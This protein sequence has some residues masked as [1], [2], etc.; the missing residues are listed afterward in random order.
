MMRR[1]KVKATPSDFPQ[2]INLK[3]LPKSICYKA[4]LLREKMTLKAIIA[5]LLTLL[6]TQYAVS[7]WEIY[8]LHKKLREKEYILAP[9]VMDFTTA[10]PQFVPDA[11]VSDAVSDFIS[12][13][14]NVNA[15]NI[16]QQY[17][18]LQRFMSDQLKIA[19]EIEM[20]NWIE[21]V[22]REGI[23]Q[24]ISVKDKE[25]ITN[26]NGSYQVVANVLVDYYAGKQYLGKEDQVIEMMLKLIP[27]E[28]GKR[29]Y[30][31]IES[32]SWGKA[33]IFKIKQNLKQ[34]GKSH[35]KK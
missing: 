12:N 7:R 8:S 32:L 26:D 20:G 33:D 14:G 28:R 22:K 19:F 23:A 16:D 18:G 9:G 5:I 30:L 27:P 29:W 6:C 10:S 4:A 11:Y 15:N 1:V 24:I 34:R 35:G 17:G 21:Q 2:G 3:L 25:I 31:Q 13:L